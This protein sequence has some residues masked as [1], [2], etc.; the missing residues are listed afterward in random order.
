MW[1]RRVHQH[2]YRSLLDEASFSLAYN[3]THSWNRAWGHVHVSREKKPGKC[4][5][6]DKECVIRRCTLPLGRLWEHSQGNMFN[7]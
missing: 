2:P 6:M 5:N 7:V 1:P 4:Y 3:I